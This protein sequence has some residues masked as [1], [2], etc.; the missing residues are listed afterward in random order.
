MSSAD[1]SM[2][3]ATISVSN[4]GGIDEREVTF[5]PGVTV[6]SGRNATNRTSLL[7]AIIAGMGGDDVSLKA[8]S[9]E[10]RVDVEIGGERYVRELYREG[11]TVLMDGDPYLEDSTVADLFA[12]LLET[13]EARR[14][15]VR[16][17]NLR[18]LIMR[19]VDT[20]AIQ[21][22]IDELVEEKRRLDE[23][24]DDLEALER[25]LPELE[26]RRSSLVDDIDDK[27]EELEATDAEIEE[28]NADFEATQEDV[29]ELERKLEELRDVRA[30]LE[31]VRVDLE[32]KQD[33]LESL[34][35]RQDVLAADRDELPEAPVEA[36]E[37]LDSRIREFRSEAR[38]VESTINEIQTI[39]QFNEEQLAETSGDL[40]DALETGAGSGDALTDQLVEPDETVCWTCGTEVDPS[41]IEET[42]DRFRELHQT[43]L[44]RKR[45]LNEQ[46]EELEEDKQ[47]YER[48]RR[49]RERVERELEDVE[50]KITQRESR[51]SDLRERRAALE[52]T[53]QELEETVEELRSE[54][55]ADILEKHERAN[56]LEF[57]LGRLSDRL[58]DVEDEIA[59]IEARLDERDRL[60]TE[61]AEVTD[62]LQELRTR[63]RRLEADAVDQ[64][65]HHMAAILDVLEFNNLD[66]IWIERTE[67]EV[68]RGRENVTEAV[69]D[70]NIVRSTTGG[71]SYTDNIDNLSESEREVTGLIFALAGYLVHDVH[72]SVPFML[73]DSLE[74]LDS[75]RI[76]GLVDYFSEYSEYLVVALLSEDAAAVDSN[77]RRIE[78]N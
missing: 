55:H 76:A 66:R 12:F 44:D 70:L 57:D 72:E 37:E 49:E 2:Q 39:I 62:E 34:R 33:G 7:R 40:F 13:N 77:Y 15:V 29:S 28:S 32:T 52:E 60:E 18:E 50:K 53:A 5:Q 45:S 42:L 11:K 43:K 38:S 35:D 26:Q 41:H 67:T 30:D 25:T 61:R 8:D 64:F 20:D 14:A 22:Q 58:G 54:E 51:I 17:E 59:T 19:P 56:Q 1:Q 16:Q 47:A 31:S 46:I 23:Q 9:D 48:Q 65:N 68:R 75:Q 24:L 71:A 10:G 74:P 27:Q 36:V 4:V 73:L 78:A 21:S 69:F 6:L 63:V 3:G